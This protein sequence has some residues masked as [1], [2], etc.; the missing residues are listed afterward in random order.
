MKKELTHHITNYYQGNT[1][2]CIT[3]PIITAEIE[4]F[5][6]QNQLVLM[7]YKLLHHRTN[8]Y[9]GNTIFCI[10]KLIITKEM[11][12]LLPKNS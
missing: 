9:Q 12:N 4:A 7:K 1:R 3:E 11:Q 10:T 8:Y 5:A 6:S 2:F